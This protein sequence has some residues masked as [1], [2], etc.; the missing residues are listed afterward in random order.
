MAVSVPYYLQELL[1]RVSDEQY[2]LGANYDRLIERLLTLPYVFFI[3]LNYDVLLDR[4]LNAHH[5]LSGSRDYLSNDGW[6]LLK[7]HGSVNWHYE[8]QQAVDPHMPPAQIDRRGDTIQMHAPNASLTGIRGG[9][10]ST[11]TYPALALPL[12]PD[13]EIVMPDQ[14]VRFLKQRINSAGEVDLLTVGYSG[15]DKEILK[16]ITD[17]IALRPTRIRRVTVV[18]HD[19]DEAARVYQRLEEA[20]LGGLW[21]DLSV[22]GFADWVGAGRLDYLVDHYG[23]GPTY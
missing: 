6:S 4:R 13:D 20:G 1:Y 11:A 23:E 21:A 8:L 12:G 15:Y 9:P 5:L 2:R 19:S 17:A 22:Y 14:H 10:A 3:T 16:L 7:P 18:S